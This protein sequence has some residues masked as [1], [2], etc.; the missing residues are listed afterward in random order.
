MIDKTK[1]G[2]WRQRYTEEVERSIVYYNELN[3]RQPVTTRQMTAEEYR[4]FFG[5]KRESVH[6][7]TY[8]GE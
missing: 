7:L 8:K 2:K 4:F 6:K 3:Q 1:E 5:E